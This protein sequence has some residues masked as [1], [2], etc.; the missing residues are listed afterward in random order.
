MTVNEIYE[1]LGSSLVA[2]I[3]GQW[4]SA[5]FDI[6]GDSTYAEVKASFVNNNDKKNDINIDDI[7]YEVEISIMDL[8][9]ITTEG[10]NNRWNRALFQIWPNNK[11]NMEF[12]WDQ[13][14]D[15]KI[16]ANS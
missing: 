14:L 7:P 11:F 16:K 12:I 13:E 6:Q 10:G 4:K 8:H 15:D 2:C 1:T 9:Q 3:P 5:Q